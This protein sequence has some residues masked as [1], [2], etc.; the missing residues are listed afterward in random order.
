[1]PDAMP[2]DAT[3][4][5][6]TSAAV[7]TV[8]DSCARGEKK[9]LSGPAVAEALERRGFQI[10]ARALVMDECSA[11]Q[12]K[13]IEM[14]GKARL[15]VTTG[16]TGIAPRDVTPEATRAVC[17]RLVEGI[18]ELMRW[19][20]IRQT[21]FAA[22]GRGVCGVRGTSL[23]LNLPGSPA[24]AVESLESVI[25]ILP[26]ALELLGGKTEHDPVD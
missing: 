15:V 22:L 12:G 18:A 5:N 17:E 24:G 11:I 26:H 6:A 23:I 14:S 7:L 9:D 2:S 8:S 1:M 25:D 21:R 16:G 19:E 4:S 10:I 13:M 3:S 20:G